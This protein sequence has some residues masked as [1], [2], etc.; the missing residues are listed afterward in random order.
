MQQDK[1]LGRI[2]ERYEADDAC[3]QEDVL[4]MM[5]EEIEFENNE[6]TKRGITTLTPLPK[7]DTLLKYLRE[8]PLSK[9]IRKYIHFLLQFSMYLTYL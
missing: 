9:L 1:I 8:I 7:R 6:K 2:I 4:S 5:E 3:S